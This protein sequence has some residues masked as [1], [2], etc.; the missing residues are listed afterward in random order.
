MQESSCLE[1]SFKENQRVPVSKGVLTE[2]G[3]E[4][5]GNL[6]LLWQYRVLVQKNLCL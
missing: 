4:V 1:P 6:V 2:A 5:A 3:Y